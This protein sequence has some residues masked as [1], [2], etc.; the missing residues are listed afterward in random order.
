LHLKHFA[1]NGASTNTKPIPSAEYLAAKRGLIFSKNCEDNVFARQM[2]AGQ[3]FCLGAGDW[4]MLP[5]AR[6][7]QRPS[8][9]H[10]FHIALNARFN[11]RDRDP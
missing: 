8:V 7:I 2:T 4:S 6:L 1:R 3:L 5:F 11:A 10:H 9:Q